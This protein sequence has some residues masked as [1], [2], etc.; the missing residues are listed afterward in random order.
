MNL[1]VMIGRILLNVALLLFG[2]LVLK[3]DALAVG[4]GEVIITGF[5]AHCD[6]FRSAKDER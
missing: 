4:I 2:V 1:P 5:F 6:G 3:A